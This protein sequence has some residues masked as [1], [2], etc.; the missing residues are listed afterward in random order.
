MSSVNPGMSSGSSS[1]RGGNGSLGTT[2]SASASSGGT[3][4]GT[5]FP[6]AGTGAGLARPGPRTGVGTE[7]SEFGAFLDDLSEL[8]RGDGHVDLRGEIER[9]VS[10]A[11][12][13]MNAALD[14]GM[15]MTV[16]AREQMQR[17]LDVSREAV[18]DRPLSSIALAAVG[19]LIVGLLL[20]RRD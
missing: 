8:A 10:Q 15:A 20:S 19:G 9:R 18:V 14:Q 5:A 6:A 17:G 7:R 4:G 16:R 12:G 13:R 1:D 3:D 2:P 11:R